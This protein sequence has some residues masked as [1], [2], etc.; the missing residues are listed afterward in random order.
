VCIVSGKCIG[1]KKCCTDAINVLNVTSHCNVEHIVPRS[2]KQLLFEFKNKTHLLTINKGL[3][4]NTIHTSGHAI[5]E[6]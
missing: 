3:F 2:M 1:R 4:T 5:V 6:P